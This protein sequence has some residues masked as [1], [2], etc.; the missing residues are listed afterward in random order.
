MPFTLIKGNFHP[1]FGFPD[2]DSL[3]FVPDN[4]DPIFKLKRRN[5]P[6]KINKKM[7]AFNYVMKES[8]HLKSLL[9]NPSPAMLPPQ[10]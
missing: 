9:L 2:G 8:I 10:I 4:P 1:E 6:P 3:R 5:F 7:A